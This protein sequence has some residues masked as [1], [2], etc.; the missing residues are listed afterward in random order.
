MNGA[1]V[2]FLL[3]AAL[4]AAANGANDVGKGVATLAGSG[5]TSYRRALLWGTVS[6]L[7]GAMASLVLAGAVTR[8]FASGF[9]FASPSGAGREAAAAGLAA[10]I[11]VMLASRVGGPVSTTHAIAGGLVGAGLA[12]GGTH[13]VKWTALVPKVFIPLAA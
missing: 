11:W 9:L 2:L 13:M 5:V 4:L 8:T 10:T 7:A 3:I 6:T 12:S 1:F